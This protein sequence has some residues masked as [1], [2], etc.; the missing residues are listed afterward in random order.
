MT[1]QRWFSFIAITAAVALLALLAWG[2]ARP[3]SEARSLGVNSQG[4]IA[5]VDPKPA[6]DMRLRLFD[7]ASANWRLSDQRGKKVV[8]NFWASWCNPC[9][10]EAGA[11]AQAARDY[12]PRGI[13]LVGVNVWDDAA[14]AQGFI[15]EF[16]IDY[17]NGRDDSGTAAVDYGVTGI[18]E[19]FV[20]DE[21]GQITAHWIGPL[22]RAALD[23]MIAP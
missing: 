15:D 4:S 12:R 8:I 2:L 16:A 10:T 7:K 3:S 14:A 13:V 19:T 9:R 11:L 17:A 18:P 22:N 1:S 21:K 6:P 5:R 23:S 20:V